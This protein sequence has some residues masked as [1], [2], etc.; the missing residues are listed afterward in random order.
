MLRRLYRA[1]RFYIRLNYSWRV[2]WYKP[3]R[4]I[5]ETPPRVAYQIYL[6][7]EI[8]E[9]CLKKLS[10]NKVYLANMRG[11]V[12]LSLIALL[13]KICRQAGVRIGSEK[14][15][16][17]LKEQRDNPS[18]MWLPAIKALIDFINGYYRQ[19]SAAEWRSRTKELPIPNYFK[20][21]TL[22]QEL[23]GSRKRPVA[24]AE[25]GHSPSDQVATTSAT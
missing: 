3:Y 20:N 23:T 10:A 9:Q 19:A 2:A 13:C 14:Y 8:M 1:W 7:A 11:Y 17:Y 6:L 18:A 12:D 16:Q 22:I 21:P 24:V 25:T 15:E 5:I 4:T